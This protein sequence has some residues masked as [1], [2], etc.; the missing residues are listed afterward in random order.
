MYKRRKSNRLGLQRW[1]RISKNLGCKTLAMI[2]ILRERRKT[3]ISYIKS[4]YPQCAMHIC[5]RQVHVAY[6]ISAN[7]GFLHY[8]FSAA[9]GTIRWWKEVQVLDVIILFFEHSDLLSNMLNIYSISYVTLR[10]PLPQIFCVE[11][12]KTNVTNRGNTW[13]RRIFHQRHL[14]VKADC[15]K[16]RPLTRLP[17]QG[18]TH[19]CQTFA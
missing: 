11:G 4:P 9:M 7:F 8:P 10:R 16:A 2:L 13:R 14:T 19:L 5:P 1:K 18:P 17:T 12:T 6:F 15:R 3:L